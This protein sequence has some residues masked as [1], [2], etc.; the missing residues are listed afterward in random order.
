MNSILPYP[1]PVCLLQVLVA[2]VMQISPH[3]IPEGAIGRRIHIGIMWNPGE[4]QL[5]FSGGI[6][7]KQGS[8]L[9]CDSGISTQ[10]GAHEMVSPIANETFL[11]SLE[12]SA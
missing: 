3:F 10:R 6:L 4:F 2:R 1:K 11:E 7:L 9:R 12:T 8:Y 5:Y